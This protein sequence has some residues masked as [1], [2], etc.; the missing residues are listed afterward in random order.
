MIVQENK[1]INNTTFIYTHSNT[2]MIIRQ[3]DTGFLYYEAYD[4]PG[5]NHTYSE[6]DNQI[7]MIDPITGYVIM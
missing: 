2:G 3:N 5:T 1:I 4:V 7:P 6:T